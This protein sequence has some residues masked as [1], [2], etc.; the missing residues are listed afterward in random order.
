MSPV[1]D[2]FVNF[3]ELISPIPVRIGN[4]EVIH[5]IGKGEID[6]YVYNG[7]KWKRNYLIPVL[8]VP[9]LKYNLFSLSSALDKDLK[10]SS[11]NLKCRLQYK[12][13][14]VAV[15]DRYENLYKMRIKA[16][17]QKTSGN[18]HEQAWIHTK[19]KRRFKL[20]MRN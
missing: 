7:S 10:L 5:A 17:Q 15:G 12:R 8:Y 19:K 13:N 4:G 11:D 14:V 20:G 16:C 6:V 3:K 9:K 1:R 2:W 18:S